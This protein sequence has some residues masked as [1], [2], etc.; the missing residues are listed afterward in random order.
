[1]S[2]DSPAAV[3]P[4]QPGVPHISALLSVDGGV[5]SS[6]GTGGA[7]GTGDGVGEIVVARTREASRD[8]RS[9]KHRQTVTLRRAISELTNL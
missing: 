7:I 2:E 3:L 5:V 4:V 6:T 9:V 1:M 8:I